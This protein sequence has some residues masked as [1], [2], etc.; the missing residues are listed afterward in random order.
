MD[1]F[2]ESISQIKRVPLHPI[3]VRE[4]RKGHPWITKDQYSVRFPKDQLFLIGCD[5]ARKEV[6]LFMHDP[7]HPRIK[8]RVWTQQSLKNLELKDFS[9]LIWKRISKAIQRRLTTDVPAER[10]NFYMIFGE[11]DQLPGLFVQVVGDQ[12]VIQTYA[13]FWD[14]FHELLVE[15][16]SI[17]LKTFY[18]RHPFALW[19]QERKDPTQP[20]MV[21][22]GGR[23]SSNKK[24]NKDYVI[25]EFGI[26]YLV[27]FQKNYD[28]G[29]YTD[30]ASI[31]KKIAPLLQESRSVL[32][33]YSYT[34][35]FSLFALKQGANN[36][37]SV[38]LSEK[39]MGWLEQNLSMN[40]DLKASYHRGITKPVNQAVRALIREKQ[41]FDFLICDPPSASSDGK[42]TSSA[43]R[44]YEELLPDLV[45]L[46]NDG[47]H[48]LLFL[49]THQIGLQK[50]RNH[51][52]KILKNNELTGSVWE[53]QTF[54]LGEDCP[55]LR[56]FREGNY[57]KGVLL[58]IKH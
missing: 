53:Q 52:T 47:G 14:H 22:L 23:H 38:D 6:C 32:N 26:N 51:L 50:F 43:F 16:L 31:R 28:L 34:G 21:L 13:F 37:V 2:P 19:M 42:K 3:S 10:D 27:G 46:M 7:E 12:V 5:Q 15:Q 55:T 54:N 41:S 58:K 56:G 9:A 20:K 40:D 39:Y 8:G 24:K 17:A 18:E 35:A 25:Q 4:I 30:M 44:N 29:I 36:V 1:L 45:R 48:L 33:L 57:L 11:A 49:N